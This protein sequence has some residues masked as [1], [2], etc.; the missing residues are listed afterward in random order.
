METKFLTSDKVL[1]E[2]EI[3]EYSCL[4]SILALYPA[5]NHH[6][7]AKRLWKHMFRNLTNRRMKAKQKERAIVQNEY[8]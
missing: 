2:M 7:L 3:M 8:S 1:V 4:C 5:L 6:A